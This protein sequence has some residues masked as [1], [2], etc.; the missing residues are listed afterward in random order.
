MQSWYVQIKCEVESKKKKKKYIQVI[1]TFIYNLNLKSPNHALP[2][3]CFSC[4][5]CKSE[6]SANYHKLEGGG[7]RKGIR[8][9]ANFNRNWRRK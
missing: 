8:T 7:K 1:W 6:N 5:K 9:G 2:H 3:L 4:N